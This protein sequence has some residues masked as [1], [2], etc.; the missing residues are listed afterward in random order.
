MPCFAVATQKA[1]ISNALFSKFLTKDLLRKIID[2]TAQ[3]TGIT[4]RRS[5]YMTAEW[6]SDV[7]IGAAYGSKV[8][9]GYLIKGDEATV[10]IAIQGN[11]TYDAVR[12]KDAL[13]AKV[14]SVGAALLS[15]NIAQIMQVFGA[16][17]LQ[18]SYKPNGNPVITFNL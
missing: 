8:G 1:L 17:N 11:A 9:V 13:E 4:I 12:F 3:E 14:K 16:Q 2:L 10:T 18:T 5:D 6:V 15:Q 7:H